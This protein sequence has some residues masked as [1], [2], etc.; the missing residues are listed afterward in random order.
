MS[1]T[2]LLAAL[3]LPAV[4]LLPPRITAFLC[5]ETAP[6]KGSTHHKLFDRS[7]VS[8]GF[9]HHHRVPYQR[10]S[11]HFCK[12]L[13][14]AKRFPAFHRNSTGPQTGPKQP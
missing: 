9:P 14:I 8:G 12:I 7:W 13:T 3:Q 1:T 4:Q 5:Y 6:R 11:E 10:P 2:S